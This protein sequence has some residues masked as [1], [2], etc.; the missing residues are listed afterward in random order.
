[1]GLACVD[2]YDGDKVPDAE[3]HCPFNSNLHMLTFKENQQI[4]LAKNDA[5]QA[6]Q[7]K[8]HW[9]VN[10]NVRRFLLSDI[11]YP[12][13]LTPIFVSVDQIRVLKQP[14]S[15][16]LLFILHQVDSMIPLPNDFSRG[17]SIQTSLLDYCIMLVH[18]GLKIV[19]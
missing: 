9:R 4:D 1:M 10:S 17:W 15:R 13:V 18:F 12:S 8:A 19:M 7:P 16:T 6:D 14:Y 3:D 5:T 2:D 11:F